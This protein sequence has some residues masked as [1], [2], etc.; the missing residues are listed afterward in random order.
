MGAKYVAKIFKKLEV[1]LLCSKAVQT[2]IVLSV[3]LVWG[4]L[5]I[6]GT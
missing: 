5:P 6:L 2:A 4:C 1:I 3:K